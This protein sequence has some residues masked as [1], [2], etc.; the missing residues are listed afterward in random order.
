MAFL[1]LV[2]L[3]IAYVAPEHDHADTIADAIDTGMDALDNATSAFG[4]DSHAPP[5]G[6]TGSWSD[7]AAHTSMGSSD[8]SLLSS[9]DVFACD[10][11]AVF[12]AFLAMSLA[13]VTAAVYMLWAGPA[14]LTEAAFNALLAGGLA[15]STRQLERRGWASGVLRSTVLPFLCILVTAVV[16]GSLAAH[17]CPDA[18]R[19]RDVIA[20][21]RS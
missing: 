6:V 5:T 9:G 14:I 10:E 15:R 13:I 2:R 7:T 12:V 3:W 1:L 20:C 4:G 16:F 11:L 21:I 17:C 8:D 18:V 19:L